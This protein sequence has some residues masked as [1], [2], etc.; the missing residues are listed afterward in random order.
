MKVKDEF[1][2]GKHDIGYVTDHFLRKFGEIEIE[3]GRYLPYQD[4]TENMFDTDIKSK[5]GVEEVTFGDILKTLESGTL[6][7]N[8]YSNIFYVGGFVVCVFWDSGSA[9]W[10]VD[11]WELDDGDWGAGGRV[12]SRNFT[13]GPQNSALGLSDPLL[14]IEEI[15]E[16]L[17]ALKAL[18]NINTKE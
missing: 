11:V 6:V 5:L 2:V 9:G 10:F 16:K 17:A 8:G 14:L 4:L 13:S 3:G 15:E 12:F 1:K 7:K 18:L